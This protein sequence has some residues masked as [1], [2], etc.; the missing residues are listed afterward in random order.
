MIKLFNVR[1]MTWKEIKYEWGDLMRSKGLQ[2]INREPPTGY[3]V[4]PDLITDQ[5]EGEGF[6]IYPPGY[7][8]RETN[9]TL[10]SSSS[11]YGNRYC[12]TLNPF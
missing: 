3:E 11:I 2:Q 5:V 6:V 9:H 4:A 10:T 8:P 7:D 12:G 1:R